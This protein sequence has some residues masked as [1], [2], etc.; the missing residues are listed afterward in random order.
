MVRLTEADHQYVEKFAEVVGE[1]LEECANANAS[2]MLLFSACAAAS[3]DDFIPMGTFNRLLMATGYKR[4]N[5]R[6]GARFVG[7]RPTNPNYQGRVY[8]R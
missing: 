8:Y 5:R 6:Y 3:G 1:A 4:T 2:T 7:L